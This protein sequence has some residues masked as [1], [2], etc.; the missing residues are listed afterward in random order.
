VIAVTA[1]V[2]QGDREDCIAAGMSDYITK[3]YNRDE[4]RRTLSRWAPPE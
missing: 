1:N 3:P 2:M 4:L